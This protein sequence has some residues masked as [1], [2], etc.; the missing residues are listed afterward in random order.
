LGHV[1]YLFFYLAGGVF[2]TFTHIASIVLV[3]TFFPPASIYSSG[4]I[5]P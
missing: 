5:V 1:K 3:E 2:A 4:L